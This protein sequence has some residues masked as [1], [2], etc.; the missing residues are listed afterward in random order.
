MFVTAKSGGDET[1]TMAIVC[2]ILFAVDT[3]IF[4]V[5]PFTKKLLVN[6]VELTTKPV[7]YVLFVAASI[8]NDNV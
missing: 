8:I 1:F 4:V 2:I 5:P 3:L 7:Q 6:V